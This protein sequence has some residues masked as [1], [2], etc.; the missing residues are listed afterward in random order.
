MQKGLNY[1][2]NA[3]QLYKINK[4]YMQIYDEEDIIQIGMSSKR[5]N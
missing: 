2:V 3:I 4:I 1:T 5:Y